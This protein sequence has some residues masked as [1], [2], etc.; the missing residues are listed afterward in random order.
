MTKPSWEKEDTPHSASA[1]DEVR[2]GMTQVTPVLALRRRNREGSGDTWRYRSTTSRKDHGGLGRSEGSPDPRGDS[3]QT[4]GRGWAGEG[5]EF[6]RRGDRWSV[7]KPRLAGR[8]R[9]V[10]CTGGEKDDSWAV[11]VEGGEWFVVTPP[12]STR[13]VP[14]SSGWGSGLVSRIGVGDLCWD[15]DEGCFPTRL[16][17]GAGNTTRRVLFPGPVA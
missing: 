5:L 14:V 12:Q 6:G 15:G 4:G 9:I 10:G 11:G 8:G 17:V 7:G 1:I 2:H 16:R 3:A 13:K